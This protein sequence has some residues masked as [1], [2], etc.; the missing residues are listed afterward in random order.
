MS[1]F[2][3]RNCLGLSILAL[4]LLVAACGQPSSKPDSS[5]AATDAESPPSGPTR[6]A[7]VQENVAGES[8]A[9]P[10]TLS[11]PPTAPA[12]RQPEPRFVH[13]ELPA[14]TELELELLDTL[15]SGTNQAG[16]PV[17]ARLVGELFADGQHVAPA[18]AEVLGTVT[19]VV[20]LKK[21]GGQP[22][23][24]VAFES[25]DVAGGDSVAIVAWLSEAGKKQ[26]ARDAAK[27]G[28]GALVGAV[29]GH[30]VDDDKGSE[31]GAVVGGAVGTAI[32][33]KTGQ[34]IELEAGTMMFVV[35]ENDAAVRVAD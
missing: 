15:S 13:V 32:A 35:L 34:E 12:V 2:R 26:T 4:S 16:D 17:R 9:R 1:V 20:P 11:S 18:G 5:A 33:A 29:V 14:G 25:L 22:Q 21:F 28:A 6:V 23:I 27:I 19:E 31:I 7:L 10:A 24:S 8:T 3:S 30:Q